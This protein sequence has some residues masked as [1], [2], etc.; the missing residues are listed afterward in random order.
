M[1]AALPCVVETEAASN[2]HEVEAALQGEQGA[3]V[4]WEEATSAW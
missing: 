4:E 2:V 3:F 1:V